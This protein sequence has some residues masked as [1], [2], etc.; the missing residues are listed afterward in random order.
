MKR[1]TMLVAAAVMAG[2]C[3]AGTDDPAA[4]PKPAGAAAPAKPAETAALPV[5]QGQK[6]TH[7]MTGE[8]VSVDLKANTITL[9]DEKGEMKT[10]PVMAKPKTLR[11]LTRVKVGERVVLTCVDGPDGEHR[12]IRWITPVK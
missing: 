10:F 8:I 6:T 2:A 5:D 11:S 1:L 4:A 3:F 9:K 7:D 12:G